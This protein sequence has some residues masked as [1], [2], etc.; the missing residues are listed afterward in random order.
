MAT[1]ALERG[2]CERYGLTYVAGIDEAGRGALAGPV[3]AAAIILPLQDAVVLAELAE[4]DDSKKLTA[5][6]RE[7]LFDLVQAKAVAYG[8]GVESARVIDEI[9]IL[10]A[11]RRAMMAAVAQLEPAPEFLLLD[12]R[13][14]LH[15][16]NI[17]Q[18]SVIRGDK[19]SLSIAAASILA[20]VT[21][22]R[23]MVALAERYPGYGLA[24]HKGYGTKG[25]LAAIGERGPSEIH[26]HSFAPMKDRL[27]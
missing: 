9:G 11:N 5:T 1:V 19:E 21:R 7:R 26:R 22:D 18:K 16:V 15:Q 6:K 12:G 14:R 13:M 24:R 25:H 17:R 2:V 20:K 4:V 27:L 8:V 10:P 23:L 3:V